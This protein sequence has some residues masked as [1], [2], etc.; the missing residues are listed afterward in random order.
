MQ[1]VQQEVEHHNGHGGLRVEE[2][3]GAGE[4]RQGDV[5]PEE[6][7]QLTP[8]VGQHFCQH[9]AEHHAHHAQ[10]DKQGSEVGALAHDPGDVIHGC[11]HADKARADVAQGQQQNADPL[12]V[13]PHVF[14]IV[15]QFVIGL[16]RRTHALAHGRKAEQEHAGANQRQHGHRHLV[17]FSFVL[18]AEP[19]GHRQQRQRQQQRGDADHHEAVGLTGHALFRIV[20]DH[21]AQRAVRN[22]DGRIGQR[23]QEVGNKGI[24]NFAVVGPVRGGKH[25]DAEQRIGEGDP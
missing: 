21:A 16:H 24:D 23:E 1:D 25:Q 9:A 14:Q 12:V 7:L 22:I 11:R 20:G 3:E 10:A 5:G 19:V 6:D 13:L 15:F 18:A 8:A 2:V 4:N 17:A